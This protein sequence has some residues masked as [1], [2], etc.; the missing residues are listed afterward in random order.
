[1]PPVVKLFESQL[2]P[3]E[4]G[5]EEDIRLRIPPDLLKCV[6][7]ISHDNPALQYI[8]TAFIVGVAGKSGKVYPHAVTAKHVAECID[9]GPF[10]IGVNFKDGKAGWLSSNLKWWYHP[11]EPDVD[12]AAT[13]FAHSERCDVL[14]V[15]ESAFVTDEKIKYH[16]IGPGDE[17]CVVG[18]FTEFY[19]S[20]KH[21]PV[22]RS[23][24]I[25]MMPSDK[26]RTQDGEMEVYLAE[27]RS[28][29]GL[30]GSPVFVH[31]S[32]QIGGMTNERGEPQQILGIGQLHFLGLM[33]GHWDLPVGGQIAQAEA[34]N[35]GI[36]IVIP[37][38]KILEVLYQPELAELRRKQDEQFQKENR[39]NEK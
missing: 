14:Y 10:L 7:F 16:G 28:I 32:V 18:L 3:G 34:V 38:K 35:M 2:E 23:G 20:T 15:P 19:G 6:A 29:G 33:R 9:G 13:V 30:S 37:A 27:G 12:V 4:A 22:V 31:P 8:G 25:A 39:P 21:I 36:S 17:V 24:N 11:T 1:V 26:I 5:R